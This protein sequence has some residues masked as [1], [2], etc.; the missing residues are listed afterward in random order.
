MH[1]QK[2]RKRTHTPV[3]NQTVIEIYN[4][5]REEKEKPNERT[6]QQ[7]TR[8]EDEEEGGKRRREQYKP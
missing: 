8:V 3:R 5:E 2:K 1:T 6:V 4:Y 7:R